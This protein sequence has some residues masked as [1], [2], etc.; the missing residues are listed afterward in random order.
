MKRFI[1]LVLVFLITGATTAHAANENPYVLVEEVASKTFDRIKAEQT[2][3]QADPEQLRSIMEQELMPYI[4]Y[5]FAAY[6]VLGKHFR[7]VPKEKIQEYVSVFREYLITTYALAMAYYD[8]QVVEFAPHGDIEG[9]KA[10]TVRAEVKDPARPDI[11]IAFQVRKNSKTN[12]WKA[13][14]MIAEGISLL[15]S[16]RSEFES[17][18]RQDGIDEVLNIMRKTIEQP[19][20]LNNANN[21]AS[22]AASS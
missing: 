19:I 7:S 12:E 11:K 10:V 18:L 20:N 9:K 6:K 4:D 13:Y 8:N 5:Q 15:D 2:K 21:K 17:V 3:I 1:A 22:T 14:D 16:K